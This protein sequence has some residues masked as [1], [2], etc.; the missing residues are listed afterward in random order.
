MGIG[1]L[2]G[3]FGWNDVERVILCNFVLAMIKL[4]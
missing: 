3:M 4:W 2:E 1:E